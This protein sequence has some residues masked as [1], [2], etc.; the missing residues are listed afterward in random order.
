MSL[1][2]PCL[3]SAPCAQSAQRTGGNSEH[4][5]SRCRRRTGGPALCIGQGPAELPRQAPHP[6][7]AVPG[8]RPGRHLRAQSWARHDAAA[9]PDGGDREQERRGGRHRCRLRR[10]GGDRR[11]C[12]G[13]D[14][15]VGRRHH[16]E[17]DAQDAVRSRQGP[18]AADPGGARPGG[19]CRERQA[20][21]QRPER[22]HRLRQG[23]SRQGHLRL[24]RDRRHHPSR[25]RTVQARD[26][27]RPLARALSRCGARHQ[28]PAG[29]HGRHGAARHLGA[30]AACPL[31]RHQDPGRDL[32][33]PPAA[34]ARRADHARARASPG[35]I[36]TTGTPWSRPPPPPSRRARRSSMPPAPRSRRRR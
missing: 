35:S 15:R 22:L 19:V 34:A 7:R 6:G 11:P 28:R 5:A 3:P 31:G 27:H 26:R 13:A 30:A 33:Y 29:G 12:H 9:G 2:P 25:D 16:A 18:R 20:R 24:G 17:P 36:P 10:Q 8:R 32:R 14:E 23:Q 1:A 4:H 21:H